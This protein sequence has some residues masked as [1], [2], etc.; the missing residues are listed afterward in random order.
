[1]RVLT[2]EL[3]CSHAAGEPKVTA[4]ADAGLETVHHGS[5]LHS[6]AAYQVDDEYDHSYN[7]QQVNKA[8]CDMKAESQE[9]HNY[10]DDENCPKHI[11]LLSTRRHPRQVLF[12]CFSALQL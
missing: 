10:E 8:A 5:P 3:D 4:R 2:S 6:P 7:Q 12:G 9:P 11:R 1:M